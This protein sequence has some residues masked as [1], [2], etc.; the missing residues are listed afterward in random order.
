MEGKGSGKGDAKGEESGEE[1]G[2]NSN[3]KGD[4]ERSVDE[5]GKKGS[6]DDEGKGQ[7]GGKAGE[8]G[9]SEAELQELYEIYKLQEEIK[10]ELEKQLEDIISEQDRKLAERILRQMQAF[11]EDLLENGV[12]RRTKDRLNV[13]N[14][15]LLK[16]KDAELKQGKKSERESRTNNRQYTNPLQTGELED[17]ANFRQIE[18]LDRQALPLRQIYKKRVQR[19]FNRN[20]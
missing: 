20:D 10:N 8:E 15:Q 4:S 14:Y 9:M 11:Q 3:G 2:E 12:T 19:Y 6:G 18:I 13:I 7:D 1:Q 5:E 17:G 16:L